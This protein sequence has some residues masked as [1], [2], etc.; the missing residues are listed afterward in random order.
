MG[1]MST[2]I[3]N[4]P[5]VDSS[6]QVPPVTDPIVTDVLAEMERE[7]AAAQKPVAHQAPP[8]QAHQVHQVH[9]AHHPPMP[10]P[11]QYYNAPTQPYMYA[12]QGVSY[13]DTSRLQTAFAAAVIAGLMLLPKFPNIYERV[14][15]IAFLEPY[16]LYIRVALLA[17]V[18]YILMIRFNL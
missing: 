3:N 13:V 8:H 2:P 11:G 9:Q 18:L 14:A 6:A 15:R 5:S 16:E 17:L 4:L 7:V 1:T 12:K 10:M